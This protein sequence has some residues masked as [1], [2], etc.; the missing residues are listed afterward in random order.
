MTRSRSGERSVPLAGGQAE[1]ADGLGRSRGTER[2]GMPHNYDIGDL[3]GEY[4]RRG[5]CQGTRW[6]GSN[7]MHEGPSQNE[8]RWILG[9]YVNKSIP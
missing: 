8:E 5:S 7:E 4:K 3:R 1:E 6:E 9:G 2:R